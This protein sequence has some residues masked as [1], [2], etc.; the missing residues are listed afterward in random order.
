[1]GAYIQTPQGYTTVPDMAPVMDP[2]LYT[3]LQVI[4]STYGDEVTFKRKYLSKFG[5]NELVGTAFA[6]IMT[7]PSGTL[8]E[9]YVTTNIINKISSSNSSIDIRLDPPIIAPPSSDIRL[10]SRASTS[11]VSVSGR[12]AGYLAIIRP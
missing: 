5:Q 3:A 1:M 9:T 6:T 2:R 7:L 12:I 11:S 4:E 10:R 8:N